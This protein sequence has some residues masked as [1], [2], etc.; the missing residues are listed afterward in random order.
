MEEVC[1]LFALIRFVPVFSTSVVA[2]FKFLLERVREGAQRTRERA[3]GAQIAYDTSSE[4]MNRR[5]EAQ[6][7]NR[8]A[9]DI[10]AEMRRRRGNK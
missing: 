7:R 10:L 2:D 9:D 5:M 6:E 8:E 3:A 1:F 4:A